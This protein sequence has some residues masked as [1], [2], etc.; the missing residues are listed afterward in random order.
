MSEMIGYKKFPRVESNYWI[1]CPKRIR[2]IFAG[3]TVADSRKAKLF[4]GHPKA[5]YFPKDHVRMEC[6]KPSDH[7]ETGKFGERQFFHV[8]VKEHTVDNAAWE[9]IDPPSSGPDVKGYLR[10]DWGSMAQWLV[11]DEPVTVGPRDPYTRLD[12]RQSSRDVKV[13]V[14]GVTVAESDLPVMLFET[15]VATRFYLYRTDVRMDLL[16]PTDKR[17]GCP[18]KGNADY[19]SI[20]VD[21]FQQENVVWTYPSPNPQCARLK[22]LLCFYSE[23][24]DGFY[25]DGEPFH[26]VGK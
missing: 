17:S 21:E 22:N 4:R 7:E 5:Y 10:F 9:F 20:M 24:I 19:Y 25:V 2:T 13:I 6:L 8:R 16:E 12:I 11:E 3:K 23:K 15:G 14:N 1:D 18:Y 26:Q